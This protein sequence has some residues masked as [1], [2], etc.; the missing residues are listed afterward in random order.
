MDPAYQGM[1]IG[2]ELMKHIM[3]CFEDL[4]YVKVI[5]SDPKTEPFYARYGFEKYDNYSAMVK[6]HFE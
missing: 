3:A 1:H 5:P 4:L 6:K 2:D